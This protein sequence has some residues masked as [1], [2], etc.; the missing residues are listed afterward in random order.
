[1]VV[2][3]HLGE[4]VAISVDGRELR[5]DI[6][7]GSLFDGAIVP[8]FGLTGVANLQP[9]LETL[10]DLVALCR[11]GRLGP[12]RLIDG[13]LPRLVEALRVL[14][15]LAAGESLRGIATILN[16]E[17]AD[18]PGDGEHV[19]SRVR[20]LVALAGRLEQLGPRGVLARIT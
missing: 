4:H 14:D 12:T 1:M 10:H 16:P 17:N 6:T 15:A 20:R 3:D 5:L 11:G 9:K 18:W 8:H 13:R 7:E 19:K 2:S